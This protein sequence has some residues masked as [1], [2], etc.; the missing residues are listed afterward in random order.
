[1]ASFAQRAQI[2][3][4]IRPPA[5]AR[6]DVMYLRGH[7]MAYGAPGM[8][9]Q[10]PRPYCSPV[11]IISLCCC[12]WPVVNPL[13]LVLC[14]IPLPWQRQRRTP[15]ATTRSQR[16]SWHGARYVWIRHNWRWACRHSSLPKNENARWLHSRRALNS[17]PLRE[18]RQTLS[19]LSLS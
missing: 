3:P 16:F 2:P 14:A 4:I 15:R 9:S 6:H 5:P 8:R 17:D 7:I 12:A 11:R 13:R 10:I 18:I 19:Y 1:M